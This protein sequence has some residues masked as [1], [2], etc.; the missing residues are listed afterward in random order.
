MSDLAET[1]WLP[2]GGGRDFHDAGN[3][4]I[5]SLEFQLSFGADRIHSDPVRRQRDVLIHLIARVVSFL[6]PPRDHAKSF[7]MTATGNPIRIGFLSGVGNMGQCAHL[8]ATTAR[9]LVAKW[10]LWLEPRP[11]LAAKV[12]A[13]YGVP[14]VYSDAEVD[15]GGRR[16]LTLSLHPSSSNATVRS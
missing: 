7:D 14:N 10:S 15:G 13:R 3:D 6:R 12:A 1:K 2:H 16:G 8:H 11:E 9:S 5:P 4:G